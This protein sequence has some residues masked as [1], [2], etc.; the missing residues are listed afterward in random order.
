MSDLAITEEK[1]PYTYAD[2]AKWPEQFRCELINGHVHFNGSLVSTVM[3]APS[4]WHQLS[5]SMIHKIPENS[6][7]VTVP[8]FTFPLAL[9]HVKE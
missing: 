2:Y 8:L 1:G 9:E 3:S 7:Q 4:F 5:S 6:N